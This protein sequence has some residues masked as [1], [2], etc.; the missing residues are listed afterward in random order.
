MMK[1]QF[2]VGREQLGKG[3]II[4]TPTTDDAALLKV[5]ERAGT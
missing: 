2:E 5:G 3:G 1:T 4:A